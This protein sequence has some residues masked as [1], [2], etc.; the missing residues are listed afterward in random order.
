[1]LYVRQGA[2][3][4]GTEVACNDDAIG[5]LTA[6]LIGGSQVTVRVTAGQTYFIFV[7]GYD[8]ESGQFTLRVT[9]PSTSLL[10]PL[11]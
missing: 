4:S 11:P 10:P 1:V 2:C 8:G 3:G 9:P 5:C 7:D 6:G